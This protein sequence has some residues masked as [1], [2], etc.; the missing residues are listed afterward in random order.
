MLKRAGSSNLRSSCHFFKC[1]LRCNKESF[2]R[3]DTILGNITRNF[4]EIAIR[5]RTFDYRM[6]H[7]EP[8]ENGDTFT[9]L[10]DVCGFLGELPS[11]RLAS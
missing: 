1:G 4:D 11:N 9:A 8:L 2:R 5:L 3:L 6:G 7:A 10:S